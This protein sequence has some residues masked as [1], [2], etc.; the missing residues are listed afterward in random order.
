MSFM[1]LYKILPYFFRIILDS[2]LFDELNVYP[3]IN[4]KKWTGF[5]NV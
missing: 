2:I 5:G 1:D 4:E 3:V